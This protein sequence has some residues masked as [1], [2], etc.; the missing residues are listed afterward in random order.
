MGQMSGKTEKCRGREV[1]VDACSPVPDLMADV[2]DI[3]LTGVCD[4]LFI[5]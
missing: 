3:R 4:A 1:V 5:D 2:W